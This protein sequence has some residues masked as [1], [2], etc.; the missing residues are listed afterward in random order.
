MDPATIGAAVSVGSSL[1]GALSGK[2]AAKTQERLAKDAV[3]IAGTAYSPVGI[4]APG[5]MG[6]T[7][8][9]G[10]AYGGGGSTGGNVVF[11][12]TGS[13]TQI[14]PGFRQVGKYGMQSD[15]GNVNLN[16]GDL[17]DPRA[18]LGALAGQQSQNLGLQG[19]SPLQMLGLGLAGQGSQFAGVDSS[20]LNSLLGLT[21]GAMG[22]AFGG[23]NDAYNNPFQA[24]LQQQLFG[25]AQGQF[26]DAA[27]GFGDYRQNTLDLLRQQ[28]APEE[29]RAFANLNQNLFSTGRMGTSGGALQ[30]EAF[31][32]GLGQA[33]LSRQ[34]MAGQE[35]RNAQT[36]ALS[37]GTGLAGQGN[38]L[39]GMQNEILQGAMSRF[40]S[41]AQ[42]GQGLSNA[43]QSQALNAGNYGEGLFGLGQQAL[44]SPYAVQS[45]GLGNLANILGL[46]G[47]IQS[48]GI[49]LAD[50]SRAFMQDQASS[51]QGQIS[52]TQG[53]VSGMTSGDRYKADLFNALGGAVG[54][55]NPL[56][57][58]A[59]AATTGFQNFFRPYSTT[60]NVFG[61]AQQE[62]GGFDLSKGL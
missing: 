18:Q 59:S 41:L 28:A 43:R 3:R 62:L 58:L 60:G 5:G 57:T 6:V 29:E 55:T 20:T 14:A 50:L 27:Q 25:G 15:L 21:G 33:D 32:R 4:S 35:A 51:R 11:P 44:T 23:L 48:Q 53:A 2:G 38:A 9:G 37:V 34:L 52:A 40:G 16:Y 8:G 12:G 36:Q 49:Q 19:L 42:L 24:A 22:Q 17:A 7:F 39:Q 10:G 13:I 54:G 45:A 61:S 1:L 46:T 47:D 31:A 26:A 56:G 30:T